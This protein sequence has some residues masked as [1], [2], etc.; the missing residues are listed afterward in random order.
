M[1]QNS[2]FVLQVFT[3]DPPGFQTYITVSGVKNQ[4]QVLLQVQN[5][6]KETL[7]KFVVEEPTQSFGLPKEWCIHINPR[8][9][10]NA[11]ANTVVALS[12]MS[13]SATRLEKECVPHFGWSQK[14]KI[15]GL[16]P[17]PTYSKV[18][19]KEPTSITAPALP[20]P[21]IP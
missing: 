14:V 12:N 20:S 2:S 1:S 3:G 4:Y 7:S 6:L 11:L 19:A 15:D 13:N 18:T 5:Y 8:Y 9:D 16:P 10:S 17:T 21:P